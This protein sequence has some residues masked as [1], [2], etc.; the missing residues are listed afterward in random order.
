MNITA[1]PIPGRIT[2]HDLQNVRASIDAAPTYSA[3]AGSAIKR[4]IE[5]IHGLQKLHQRLKTSEIEVYL[6]KSDR[7]ANAVLKRWMSHRSDHKKHMFGVVVFKCSLANAKNL[8]KVGIRVLRNLKNEGRLC[9]GDANISGGQEAETRYL[10]TH[11]C[12]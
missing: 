9:V 12:T 6:G 5:I 8:E 7:S 1:H 10:Q 2:R 3:R 11:S 4:V